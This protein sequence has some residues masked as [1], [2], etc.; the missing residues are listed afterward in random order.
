METETRGRVCA[1]LESL[2]ISG[3]IEGWSLL[4]ISCEAVSVRVQ[5]AFSFRYEEFRFGLRD[6]KE[7]SVVLDVMES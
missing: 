1:A 6:L 7:L 2:R 4:E 3:K 5:D